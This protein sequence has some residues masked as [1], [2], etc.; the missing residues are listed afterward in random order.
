MAAAQLLQVLAN[1]K[2][3]EILRI[4]SQNEISV[5]V[6]S[7]K[8]NLSQSSV[9]QHLSKLRMQNLVETRKVSQNVY[10]SCSDE[11]VYIMLACLDYIFEKSGNQ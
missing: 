4:V 7:N 9:S 6:L 1:D 10:Y 3:L 2:R 11:R 8:I 5:S